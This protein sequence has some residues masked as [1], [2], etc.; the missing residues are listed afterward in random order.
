MV[1]TRQPQRSPG[2]RDLTRRG[3]LAGAGSVAAGIGLAG[4][5]SAAASATGVTNISFYLSKPEVIGYFH[6]LISTY[7]SEQD[8]VR[9]TLD[10]STNIPASF[11]RNRPPDL[12]L[13]N[14]N[15]SVTEFVNR[16]A[17]M[18]MSAT[19]YVKDINPSVW[20]L[21]KLTADDPMRAIPYSVMAA[22]VI[23]NRDIF[24]KHH[25][26]VPTT[27]SEFTAVCDTLKAAGVTPIYGTFADSWTIAQ[28]MFDYSIG[29]MV[30]VPSFF[31]AIRAEGTKLTAD[32]PHSFTRD[33]GPP[34][35][36]MVELLKY[37]NPNASSRKYGD[38]NTAFAQGKAAMYFQ[39]PW[40][41]SQIALT[42]KN[43]N[44]GTFPLP[45]T[46]DPGDLKAR[47]NIDLA[48]WIPESCPRKEAAMDFMAW[49]LQPRINDKYNDDNDGYGARVGAPAPSNPALAGLSGFYHKNAFYLGPSQL[50]PFSIP[51]ANYAQSIALGSAPGPQL[52][53]LNADWARY[54][55][56]AS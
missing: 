30:D 7:H 40:A 32:S 10:S 12:G 56:R 34:M 5:S 26:A 21:M 20:E 18:D 54:S 51:V 49:L 25:L 33:F 17:W 16:G 4:C 45:V 35:D 39:G 42:T 41:F 47:V 29:G 3:F 2:R 22:G 9:V 44:M 38:G 48:L 50:V 24:D 43:L 36:R 53:K 8:K 14:Y 28:G 6:D 46:D 19:P 31:T 52:A 1:S 55:I 23:Y 37:H 15:L 27:W 11:V 13:W